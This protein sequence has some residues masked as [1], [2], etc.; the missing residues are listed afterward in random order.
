MSKETSHTHTHTHLNIGVRYPRKICICIPHMVKATRTLKLIVR[1]TCSLQYTQ[2]HH[3]K[4][5]DSLPTSS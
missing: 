3:K 1:M 5:T 2:N 4:Y